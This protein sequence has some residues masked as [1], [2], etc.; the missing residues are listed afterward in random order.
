MF[1]S[2]L[3]MRSNSSLIPGSH[4]E[5]DSAKTSSPPVHWSEQVVLF[6]LSAHLLFLPWA[7]GTMHVWSKTVSLGLAGAG[8]LAALLLNPPSLHVIPKIPAWKKLVTSRALW[9]G[10]A[11]LG[12]I[13]VQ[14]LNPAYKYLELA[15][16]YWMVPI[17]HIAWLPSG[18]GG[19]FEV[20]NA[21]RHLMIFG[22]AFLTLWTIVLFLERAQ[23]LRFLLWIV[24]L[25][26]L[27]VA[28]LAFAQLFT[29]TD[30]IFWKL[31]V[32]SREHFY[33][34]FIYKNH[35]A[36]YLNLALAISLGLFFYF[37][38]RSW[39]E[40]RKRADK[41]PIFFFTSAVLF[42]AV[43]FSN[44][45]AGIMIAVVL[46]LLAIGYTVLQGWR[47]NRLRETSL[48]S[49][50]FLGLLALV[51]VVF[52]VVIGPDRILHRFEQ[53]YAD[54]GEA[55]MEFRFQA[56]QATA[57][58]IRDKPLYGWGAGGFQYAFPA[59]QEKYPDIQYRQDQ[60]RVP[61]T[62]ALH[63]EHAHND[64]LQYPAEYGLAG[65]AFFLIGLAGWFVGLLRYRALR[66]PVTFWLTAGLL[67]TLTHSLVDFVL[68]NPAV[69][70]TA[71]AAIAIS[72]RLSYLD[73]LRRRGKP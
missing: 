10:L 47:W 65:F 67:L 26:G 9:L 62:Y 50:I 48:I 6:L 18:M 8:F 29:Q 13:L 68:Q 59:Y 72:L 51:V 69:I 57:D 53:L 21:F 39:K 23:S 30:Q 61:R 32:S 27:V 11:L 46:L 33:A 31:S 28:G 64:W 36:G 17:D 34:S 44:S 24:A 58:M 20:M 63:W 42:S 22:A 1:P 56:Y 5:P 60:R 3:L 41:S 54:R 71:A 16:D 45:R 7:L 19:P 4:A 43:L 25:N 15:G 38:E 73:S 70:V 55:Q 12:Y 49:S 66:Q 14:A 35:A 2:F 37:R 52:T 40:N